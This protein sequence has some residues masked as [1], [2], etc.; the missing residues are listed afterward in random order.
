[1]VKAFDGF[2]NI[3]AYKYGDYT[4]KADIV[5]ITTLTQI[6]EMD[7]ID[8]LLCQAKIL[9]GALSEP[10]DNMLGKEYVIVTLFTSIAQ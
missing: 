5:D 1:M 9:G 7:G 4:I 10:L 2:D 6:N 8:S 3:A